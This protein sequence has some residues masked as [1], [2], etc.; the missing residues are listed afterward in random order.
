MTK[1]GVYFVSINADADGATV[2]TDAGWREV[3]LHSELVRL[4]FLEYVEAMRKADNERLWPILTFR[5]GKP[6]GYFSGWFSDA[7]KLAPEPVPD[8]H[9]L[10]HTVRTK[11]TEA[12]IA[13]SVQDR[14][15]GHEVK[16]SVGATVYAHPVAIL[17]S[18]VEA[19]TYP[20]LKLP[21][22]FHPRP[23]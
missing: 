3:P 4:G 17:R 5:T 19:V 23:D 9:S 12:G 16:G 22:C 15:T 20:G 7:R 6:G 13:D 14:I 21:R 18:A 2:K 8:F 10:R 11:M 1:G